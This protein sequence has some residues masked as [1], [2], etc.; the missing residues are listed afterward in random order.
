MIEFIVYD[1]NKEYK[2]I[3]TNLIEKKMMNYDYDYKITCYDSYKECVKSIQKSSNFKI[4]IL[5]IKSRIES[6]LSIAKNIREKKSDWQ[7]MII[8]TSESQ[9]Y[10]LMAFDQ[11]LMILDYL[12][13]NNSYENNLSQTL[14]LAL[15]NYDSRP[16]TIKFSYKNTWYNISLADII[17]IEKEQDSKRCLIKTTKDAYYITGNLCKLEKRLDKRFLKC[18]RSY[19]INLEQMEE[20]NTKDNIIVFSNHETLNIISRPKRKEIVNY[21]R[22][23][24]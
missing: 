1:E 22:F 23:N 4:Y 9:D 16:N 10:K 21:F 12:L 18:N 15:K 7:S 11:R 19:I 13:K 6:G 8:L 17:Y 5:D 20:Y 24:L 14:D 2:E 3:T